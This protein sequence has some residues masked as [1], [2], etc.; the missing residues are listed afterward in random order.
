MLAETK[1]FK[2]TKGLTPRCS[3]KRT[4]FMNQPFEELA[5]NPIWA[6]FCRQANNQETAIAQAQRALSGVREIRAER[7]VDGEMEFDR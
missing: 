3:T 2:A 1:G 4:A 5:D 6:E 7:M